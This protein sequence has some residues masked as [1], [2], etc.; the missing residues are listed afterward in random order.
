MRFKALA[1]GAC[2][3]NCAAVHIYEEADEG[4]K[5]KK[6]VNNHIADN[7]DNYYQYKIAL[8]Y[9]ETVGA[10]ETA[11]IIEKNTKE[12]ML[13]FLRSEEALVVYSNSQELLAIANLFKI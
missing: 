13:V 7:W 11:S 9:R 3:T 2:L 6:R 8:P 4:P 1:N 10:G 5:V 12:E